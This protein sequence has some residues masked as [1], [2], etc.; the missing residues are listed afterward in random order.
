ANLERSEPNTDRAMFSLDIHDVSFKN[1]AITKRIFLL[2]ST[3]HARKDAATEFANVVGNKLFLVV[4][5]SMPLIQ[6]NKVGALSA[7][8]VND[9]ALEVLPEDME[10][11]VKTK[12]NKKA[13][14]AVILCLGNKVLREVTG[15]T[16]A[17]DFIFEHIDEKNEDLALLLL[18]SL[19]ASYEHFVD[20]LLSEQEALTLG[21]VMAKLNSKKI[22]ERSK[23]KG[24]DGEG[25]YVRGRTDRRDS[26]YVKKDEQPSS[27]GSTYDDS[28]NPSSPALYSPSRYVSSLSPHVCTGRNIRRGLDDAPQGDALG[29]GAIM[30]IKL[31]EESLKPTSIVL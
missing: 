20:T 12:L 2:F 13:H 17:R 7:V 26:C 29:S 30:I 10:A 22:K 19:P 1:N 16:T 5:F 27:S 9:N 15:E 11:Q 28:K 24:D 18:T 31:G 6:F 25:L 4:T 3:L 21:D 23:A 8:S 14:S